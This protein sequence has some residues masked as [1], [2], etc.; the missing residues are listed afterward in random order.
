MYLACLILNGSQN[1]FQIKNEWAIH[2]SNFKTLLFSFAVSQ[3][4]AKDTT[5]EIVTINP[6]LAGGT[7]KPGKAGGWG[8]FNPFPLNPMFDVQI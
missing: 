1:K 4:S 5:E 6:I 3:I 8:Q 7:L 2:V